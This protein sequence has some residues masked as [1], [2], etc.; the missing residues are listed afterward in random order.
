[1]TSHKLRMVG[2]GLAALACWWCASRNSP[3][4]SP[5]SMLVAPEQAPDVAPETTAACQSVVNQMATIRRVV[6]NEL[7]SGTIKA[8]A[9]ND[10]LVDQELQIDTSKCPTD[11]RIALLR[12]IT[13]EDA[14]RMHAHTDKT[15]RC[16]EALATGIEILATH[17]VASGKTLQPWNDLNQMVTDDQKQDFSNMQSA[18]LNFAQAAAKYDV[19]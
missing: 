11:F 15:G 9:A 2:I 3:V 16:D 12:F 5:A 8:D 4:P 18:Y 7:Q 1:M 13:S 17:G 19:K 14:A 6:N 10:E